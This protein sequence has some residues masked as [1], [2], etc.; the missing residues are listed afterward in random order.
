MVYNSQKRVQLYSKKA[1]EDIK[2]NLSGLEFY[3]QDSKVYIPGEGLLYQVPRVQNASYGDSAGDAE[4]AIGIE[5]IP[6]SENHYRLG[7]Q[8]FRNFY[9][10]LD[11]E[12][13]IVIVGLN[14]HG[15]N[16]GTHVNHDPTGKHPTPPTESGVEITVTIIVCLILIGLAFVILSQMRKKKE[17]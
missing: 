7:V 3:L 2:D 14:D 1:C 9:V 6:D 8:F 4:C 10:A 5:S 11:Y 15:K 13:N 17:S 12:R 16:A